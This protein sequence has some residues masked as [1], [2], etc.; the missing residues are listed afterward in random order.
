VITIGEL[1]PTLETRRGDDR[2]V[3]DTLTAARRIGA[4][5]TDSRAVQPAAVFVALRGERTD[6]HR[7]LADVFA[8]GAAAA[9]IERAQYTAVPALFSGLPPQTRLVDPAVDSEFLDWDGVSPLLIA[10]DRPLQAVQR[11]AAAHRRR[12]AL[13][14]VGITGSVGKTSVKEL[15]AAVL[16]QR[17]VTLK[18]PRSFNSEAT[19]PTV[20]LDLEPRHQAAVLEMGMWAAGE[21]A[22]LADLAQP[23]IGVVTNVGPTHL[24]RMG[25]IEAIARAKGEL[26]EALPA[27]GW[28]VLNGDDPRV[29][30]MAA[31]TAA[32]IYRFGT[33]SGLELWADE[34]I[35]RGLDGLSFTVHEGGRR[36]PIETTLVGPHHVMTALAA[37][38]VGRILGLSWDE[39]RAGL[40]DRT[41]QPRIRAL[42]GV[43][44]ST[45]I[46]DTYN[47]APVSTIAALELLRDLPGRR[48]AVLGEMLE[49]GD[50]REPGHDQVGRAAAGCCDMLL[51]IGAGGLLYEPGAREAGMP[52]EMIINCSDN[53]IAAQLLTVLL[54]ADDHVLLKGSRGVAMETIVKAI[55]L[56]ER[57]V[58]A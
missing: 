49:L 1:L 46:D 12:F 31:R 11:A 18:S 8:A 5:V 53:A 34:I 56:S 54:R 4:L 25:S 26:I 7:Y 50:E 6:G 55:S 3:I 57:E 40:N 13:P 22:L 24:E 27:D 48:I 58:R 37:A 41:A 36:I 38:A 43:N 28:A 39:I 44:G 19:L 10:V 20:L 33:T 29:A 32:R 52:S 21:I 16:A 2:L 23:Q 47:A 9:I 42:N 51:T 15:A 30:A 45:L 14:V 35:G 17:F